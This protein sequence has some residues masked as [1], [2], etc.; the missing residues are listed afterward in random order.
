MEICIVNK[1]ILNIILEQIFR[2]LF[3]N[4]LQ[5]CKE[6][7]LSHALGAKRKLN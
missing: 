2:H 7:S 5:Y 1:D 4:V 3:L 6:M